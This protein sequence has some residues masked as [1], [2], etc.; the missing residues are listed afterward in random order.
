VF[1]NADIYPPAFQ[2]LRAIT[3]RRSNDSLTDP[4]R[5]HPPDQTSWKHRLAYQVMSSGSG[6]LWLREHLIDPLVLRGNPVTRRNYEASYDVSELEPSS[7]ER[8]TYVLQEYF[9]PVDSI[10]VFLPRLRRVLQT[11]GVNAINVSIRHAL[12]DPG[13]LLAWAPEEVF[14]FVLYYKQR[15]TPEDRREVARWTRELIDAAL[16]SGG[17]YY[18]PY[19]PV[20]TREQFRRAYPRAAELIALKRRVDPTG[21]FTNVLWDLYAPGSNGQLTPVSATRMP[22]V[23]PGETQQQLDSLTGY[24]RE[25]ETAYLTHPEWDLVYSSEA[26]ARWLSKGEPPSRFAYFAA[27]GTFWRSYLGT[28]RASRE[29]YPAGVGTHVML[30]VIGMSTAIEYGIK[31][32]Y[33]KTVGRLAETGEPLRPTAEEEYA[34]RVSRDYADLIVRKGWYEFDFGSALAGLWTGVPLTGPGVFRKWERRMALTAEYGIKA[35]Y[36]KLIGLGTQ[37]AYSPDDLERK[38]VI[39]GWSD[40][41]AR[42]LESRAPELK[43]AR[44]LDRG[45]T[46]LT[47]PRYLPFRHALL[48]LADHARKLRIAEIA[49]CEIVT[50]TGTAPW[51]WQAPARA[52]VVVSYRTPAERGRVRALLSVRARD[53]LD[54]L[55]VLKTEGAFQPDHIYDY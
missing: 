54:M 11:H 26:Y 9:V 19:Q 22:A 3:Y 52:D 21:K 10:A 46:L 53:L 50:L 8:K 18:L 31:G 2:K 37:S 25:Q 27:V 55:A 13:T 28:W 47:V 39:A 4:G 42:Q 48:A 40:S 34:A 44:R 7:R 41:L 6:G 12:K 5:I 30:W 24:D 32:V 33:E 17:R 1:H 51:G 36:A 15:V 20:A 23:L 16:E 43:V 14:A 45:Y 29:A 49:G 38:I 35:V